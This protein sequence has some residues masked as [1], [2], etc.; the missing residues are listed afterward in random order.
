MLTRIARTLDVEG[1]TTGV[2]SPTKDEQLVALLSHPVAIEL[3]LAYV[4]LPSGMSRASLRQ[5]V[6]S[7]SVSGAAAS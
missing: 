3:L 4:A 6:R 7:F 2:Q 5:F 1:Q